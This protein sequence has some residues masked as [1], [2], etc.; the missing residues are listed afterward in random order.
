M[1]EGFSP[2]TWKDQPG[3]AF[4]SIVTECTSQEIH[5]QNLGSTLGPSTQEVQ[6]DAQARNYRTINQSLVTLTC[7]CQE[8]KDYT[9]GGT[10]VWRLSTHQCGHSPRHLLDATDRGTSGQIGNVKFNYVFDL[11]KGF[12]QVLMTRNLSVVNDIRLDG[13]HRY[14]ATY[15]DDL[16]VFSGSWEEHL[17]HVDKILQLIE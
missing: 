14:V 12:Y 17:Q 9:N 10:S 15:M 13:T 6:V 16:V 7:A 2:S 1:R 11:R 4:H 3:G 5:V 8:V